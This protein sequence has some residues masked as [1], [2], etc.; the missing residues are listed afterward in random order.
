MWSH[1]TSSWA[2]FGPTLHPEVLSDQYW[3]MCLSGL[4]TYLCLLFLFSAL[5]TRVYSVC[6]CTTCVH[7]S[8]PFQD[9]FRF[10]CQYVVAT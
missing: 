3:D 2:L 4:T 7:V 5:L 8:V 1:M 9:F 10:V 6:P